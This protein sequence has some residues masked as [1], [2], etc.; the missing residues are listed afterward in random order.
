MRAAFKKMDKLNHGVI[1]VEDIVSTYDCSKHPEASA[2]C[3]RIRAHRVRLLQVLNG[4]KTK[5]KV[6][7]EFLETFKLHSELAPVGCFADV[8]APCSIIRHKWQSHHVRLQPLE[9]RPETRCLIL[10]AAN[11]PTTTATSRRRLSTMTTLVKHRLDL[12]SRFD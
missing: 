6:L 1:D 8:F 4:K 5:E 7:A 9:P 11:G 3:R 10:T 2:Q 12:E